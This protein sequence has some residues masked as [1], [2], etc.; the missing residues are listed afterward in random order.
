MNLISIDA[1][2][3]DQRLNGNKAEI[4]KAMQLLKRSQEFY[5]IVNATTNVGLNHLGVEPATHVKP[6]L[7]FVENVMALAIELGCKIHEQEIGT[8]ELEAF[9]GT[10]DISKAVRV[11]ENSSAEGEEVPRVRAGGQ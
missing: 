2:L 7:E 9:F 5:R 11:S 4:S 8:R 10:N 3:N 1:V 6:M